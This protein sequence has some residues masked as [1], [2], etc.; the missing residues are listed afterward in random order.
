MCDPSHTQG[1][2]KWQQDCTEEHQR[3]TTD[4]E[5]NSRRGDEEDPEKSWFMCQTD[6]DMAELHSNISSSG[7]T[8]F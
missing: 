6:T 1:S 5:S 4:P 2:E 8:Q 7:I 3:N